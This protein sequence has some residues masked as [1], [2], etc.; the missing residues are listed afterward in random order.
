MTDH[1]ALARAFSE[2]LR[3]WLSPDEIAEAV[4]RNATPEYRG[5]CATQD[6]CDANMAMDAAF[7]R[8]TGREPDVA[9]EREGDDV[10]AWNAAWDLARAAGFDPEV[11]R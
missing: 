6:F 11:I 10:D 1:K 5:C 9:G 7:H 4:R 3:E 2:V 8:L